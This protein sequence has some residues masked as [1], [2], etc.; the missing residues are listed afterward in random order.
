MSTKCAPLAE[1]DGQKSPPQDAF[2]WLRGHAQQ[3][4][5][6]LV[7][8]N[9][10]MGKSHL[11]MRWLATLGEHQESVSQARMPLFIPLRFVQY[12]SSIERDHFLRH[13][14]WPIAHADGLPV[15]D[16]EEFKKRLDEGAFSV[17][18][19]GVDE[20]WMIQMERDA[21]AVVQR[22][23]SLVGN[24]CPQLY[25]SRRGMFGA[26]TEQLAATFGRHVCS[27]L[28][29]D[30]ELWEAFLEH[31]RDLK[32]FSSQRDYERFR[33]R[34]YSNRYLRTLIVTPLYARMLVEARDALA[35]DQAID[36]PELYRRY[37]ETV[38]NRRPMPG[39]GTESRF[40]CLRATAIHLC[41]N[42]RSEVDYEEIARIATDL[43][44][45]I[46]LGDIQSILEHDLK[47][48]SLLVN[49]KDDKL[50]FSHTSFYE[51]F[52][53]TAALREL[54]EIPPWKSAVLLKLPLEQDILKFIGMHL[55]GSAYA[56]LREKCRTALCSVKAELLDANTT[57]NL[58]KSLATA[59][60]DLSGARLR[61][62]SLSGLDLAGCKLTGS[63]FE[64]AS[65]SGCNLAGAKLRNCRFVGTRFTNSRFADADFTGSV[66]MGCKMEDLE[67][68]GFS[69]CLANVVIERAR[70]SKTPSNDDGRLLEAAMLRSE[71]WDSEE[72]MRVAIERMKKT[73]R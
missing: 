62:A 71:G 20:I 51:Y 55:E 11:V 4:S 40:E 27:L 72:R 30:E 66:F 1:S 13:G 32:I 68:A 67:R 18:L 28:E 33:E 34:V 42:R 23:R 64:A 38:L 10:G 12:H 36:V 45:G 26:R 59:G 21:V 25:T 15:A 39:I 37:I 8:S 29:W 52:V 14:L 9:Y 22:L 57:R 58:V 48:A 6:V 65:L 2:D 60:C 5:P 46:G 56:G 24:A 19:D 53:A 7:L 73:Y 41:V 43:A 63:D 3:P 44:R 50:K 16:F 17:I 49:Q 31:C 61:G 54:A 69:P 35:D 70:V 47:R